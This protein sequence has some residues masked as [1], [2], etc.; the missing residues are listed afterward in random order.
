MR[1]IYFVFFFRIPSH[2]FVI[3]N[4]TPTSPNSKICL[5]IPEPRQISNPTQQED[6]NPEEEQPS[7]SQ[8]RDIDGL[9]ALDLVNVDL[10]YAESTPLGGRKR[11]PDS[12]TDKFLESVGVS[13]YR[14]KYPSRIQP[15]LKKWSDGGEGWSEPNRPTP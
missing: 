13:T 1:N 7:S 6:P 15:D 12:C 4:R 9:A 10:Y 11:K 2:T 5:T 8:K 14:Y 3:T